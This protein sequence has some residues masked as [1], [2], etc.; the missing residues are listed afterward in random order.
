MN[1][2]LWQMFENFSHTV[3]KLDQGQDYRIDVFYSG[4]NS[5]TSELIQTRFVVINQAIGQPYTVV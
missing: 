3:T 5:A 2:K 4:N 1:K